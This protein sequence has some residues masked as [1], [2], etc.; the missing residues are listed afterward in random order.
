[1]AIHRVRR[2]VNL[3]FASLFF[4]ALLAIGGL[5]QIVANR[6]IEAPAESAT[7][8]PQVALG[9]APGI[10]ARMDSPAFTYSP[11]WNVSATGADPSEPAD[12]ETMPSGTVEFHFRGRELALQLAVGDYRGHLYVTVDGA[13]ANLLPVSRGHIPAPESPAGY[14]PLFAP[15]MV[16]EDGSPRPVW[17]VVHHAAGGDQLHTA[18]IELWR[19]WGQTPLR[20][21]G[22]DALRPEAAAIWPAL[23]MLAAAIWFAVPAWAALARVVYRLAHAFSLPAVARWILSGRVQKLAGPL[24][25]LGLFCVVTGIL[26]H[27]WSFAAL[28]I[29][30]LAVAGIVRPAFWFAALLFGLPFYYSVSLPL[31]PSRSVNLVDTGVYLGLGIALAHALL[32]TWSEARRPGRAWNGGAGRAVARRTRFAPAALL[33][34]ALIATWGLVATSAAERL[35]VALREWRTVFLMA[36]VLAAGLLLTLRSSRSLPDDVAVL[37][38]G[39]L[40][41]ATV[42]AVV[43]LARYPAPEVT[44]PAE[45]VT[46]LRGFYGSPNNLALYLE[47]TLAVML[48]LALFMRKAAPRVLC[49]IGAVI[50]GTALVLTFS[51]GALL[52]A[53]PVMMLALWVGGYLLL[54]REGRS[55]RVLWLLAGAALFAA[56]SLLPALETARFQ[57]I[58][59]LQQGTGVLRLNLWRSAWQ[60]AVDHPLLG[61]GP[62]N[63]LYAYRSGYILPQAWMEPNLNH[64]HTWLLDWWVRIGLPGMAVGL[65][66]WGMI[67]L[68]S[69]RGMRVRGWAPLFLGLLAATLAAL[70]HGL[71][72]ASYALPDLM[73]MWALFAVLASIEVLP[74]RE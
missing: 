8:M 70:A 32:V 11:G 13:P 47:R 39:W 73:A 29:V 40:A 6:G 59:S 5:Y 43:V 4:A 35:P 1:M 64:P 51:R 53:L 21:V 55:A 74:L 34:L 36:P 54:R 49:A 42:M 62:D 41:G 16:L 20:A 67:M 9:L 18:R 15:E 38:G 31:L 33:L 65:L 69:V 58:V 68:G 52:L 10:V 26:S 44:I 30:L 7:S 57:Q 46:R 50:Q 71:I 28:G 72:D 56:A 63:F 60:M 3:R 66:L 12:P 48:A 27:L 23:L 45:G 37:A 2:A 25:G 24:A 17:V 19:S 14:K 61:V 22:V